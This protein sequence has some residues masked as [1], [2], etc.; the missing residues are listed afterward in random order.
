MEYINKVTLQGK[1]G[2]IRLNEI[3]GHKVASFSVSTEL[4]SLNAYGQL[5]AEL[6]WHQV[7]A[8]DGENICDLTR[9]RKGDEVRVS[10]RIRNTRYTSADGTEKTFTEV[11]AS[12]LSIINE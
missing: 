8:W 7:C 9:L 1:V 2:A 6:T 12:E 11:L 5:M 10:G 3:Q 4:V